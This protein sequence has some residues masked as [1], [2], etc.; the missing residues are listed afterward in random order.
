MRWADAF[1]YQEDVT[2]PTLVYQLICTCLQAI[3]QKATH[4]TIRSN[5]ADIDKIYQVAELLQHSKEDCSMEELADKFNI[6]VYKLNK[7]F[8]QIYGH[9]VLHHR[10]EEKMRLALRLIHDNRY[11]IKQIAYQLDY[12]PQ[13]FIR[14]FKNRFGYT[15]GQPSTGSVRC[16]PSI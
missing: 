2:I 14:A 3:Q 10:Q 15:P 6:S 13:N 8:K 16:I 4:Y 11:N 5:Q 7:L 9:S 1:L 12:W